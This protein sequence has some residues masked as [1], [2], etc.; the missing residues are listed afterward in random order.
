MR[1]RAGNRLLVLKFC[2]LVEMIYA[3]AMPATFDPQINYFAW[4]SRM[5]IAPLVQHPFDSESGRLG[6]FS[7][8]R[9]D[10]GHY[11]RI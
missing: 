11:D 4:V 10:G 9:F 2:P 5:N 3:V 8:P 1:E 6:K 7:L